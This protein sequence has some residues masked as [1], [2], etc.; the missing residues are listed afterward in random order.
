M[1]ILDQGLLR[2][3]Y[4]YH[5]FLI[6]ITRIGKKWPYCDTKMPNYSNLTG[7]LFFFNPE[8]ADDGKH[9]E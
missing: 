4:K 8:L 7:T 3:R 6:R 1:Y 2:T 9:R 5:V